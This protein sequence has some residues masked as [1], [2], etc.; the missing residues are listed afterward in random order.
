MPEYVYRAVN[1]NGVIVKNKVEE[2]SKQALI[3]RLK[4]NELM[5]IQIVQVGYISRKQK[6]V[7]KNVTNI[8]DIMKTANSTNIFRNEATTISAI[9]K[10]NLALSAT[11]K[12]TSRDL[13]IF[14]QNFY[15]LKKANFNNIHA[16]STIIQSTENLS[17]KGI[18]EDI[19]A[20]VEAGDYMYTTMEYY[21]NVFPYIY[22][23]MIKVGELSGSLTTSLQQA[24]K[25]L[26][27]SSDIT[28]KVK[29]VL[30]PNIIQFVL[31]VVMLVVGTLVAVPAIQSVYDSVGSSYEL[32]KITVWFS[33][34]VK[35]F[36]KFWYIPVGIIAAIVSSIIFYINTPKGKYN[37]HY[38]KYTMPIFGK[39]I[40][41]L[42]FSRFTKAMLLNLN[43]GMRIQD[44]LDV[45]KNVVNNY[46]FL[47]MVETSIN[48]ILIGQSWIEPFEKSGLSSSM[49]TEM[50]KIG[51]QT[52][53]AEMMEKLVEYMEIDINNILE[54]I[55]K[56]FPEVVYSIVG[57]V[58]IFFVLVV[59]VPILETY[60]GNF[61]FD[62][63]GI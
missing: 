46:V 43:N 9:E 2:A 6:K 61:L 57:L 16:L 27:D 42:D 35:W 60:M 3:K 44:A 11:E 40:Y 15:L 31:L 56:I 38:F 18:L 51:M 19:L 58:L 10:I 52:D 17:L 47:S 30:I 7:K 50:L 41:S 37:F 14:T 63:A 59:L 21:S 4:L 54:K 13:V 22:I 25:Y 26:D 55:M 8:E 36:I 62:A 28:R 12:I 48:N 49:I 39:L 33:G 34:V 5:P 23:N 45:S 24:V 1:K 32:P 29:K 53:L 20:G